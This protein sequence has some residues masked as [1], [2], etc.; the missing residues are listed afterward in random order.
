MLENLRR[1]SLVKSYNG[2]R[3]EFCQGLTRYEDLVNTE[4]TLGNLGWSSPAFKTPTYQ[5]LFE[6]GLAR[7]G[8][9]I[10]KDVCT[11][12]LSK[13]LQ[14]SPFKKIIDT[15]SIDT[16]AWFKDFNMIYCPKGFV[17][18]CHDRGL[19]ERCPFGWETIESP[20]LLGETEV[21][22]ELYQAVMGENPSEFK[23]NSQNPVENVS[24]FDAILF[25][26]ELSRLQGL[27]QCYTLRDISTK[28]EKGI[29]Q[30]RIMSANV[31]SLLDSSVP[32]SSKNGYRLP[33]EKEW[34]YAAKAGRSD[35][36]ANRWAGTN[37]NDKDEVKKYAV[38]TENSE[39]NGKKQTH[40]VK[41]KKP[42]EWGFYDMSGNVYEWCWDNY[43]PKYYTHETRTI[44]GGSWHDPIGA[45]R[46]TYRCSNEWSNRKNTIGFRV[47]RSFFN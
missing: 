30:K 41:T 2:F 38:C 47:C 34:E 23:N 37:T 3:S 18:V 6:Q 24:W 19:Y 14:E 28:D 27:R 12:K 35:D 40:P 36:K 9:V 7:Y 1:K 32:N 26:N 21:T 25:C 17:S 8:D 4:K 10:E 11:Q 46:S 29:D 15:I 13:K 31:A 42:N 45:V 20:F 16:K 44:R 22:Q 5:I 33:R 39:I 43:D